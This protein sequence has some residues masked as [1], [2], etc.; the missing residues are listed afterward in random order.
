MSRGSQ[1]E[2]DLLRL[3]TPCVYLHLF[4]DF[5]HLL[6]RSDDDP[7][8][9]VPSTSLSPYGKRDTAT[10]AARASYSIMTGAVYCASCA[11]PGT[12]LQIGQRLLLT[13]MYAT[14]IGLVT[15]ECDAQAL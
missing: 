12:T 9:L 13:L 8:Q 11:D 10:V 6:L 2:V 1:G 7:E 4:C 5:S 14:N 3:L 15:C